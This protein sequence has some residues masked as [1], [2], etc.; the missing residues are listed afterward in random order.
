MLKK[1]FSKLV[2]LIFFLLVV[3]FSIENSENVSIGIWPISSRIEIPMFF[4]TI[5]SI[6]IGV[7]IGML[8]SL[9]SRINRK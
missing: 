2:F 5:F 8:L 4:L 9:Y 7:F 6:T 3:F 1:F